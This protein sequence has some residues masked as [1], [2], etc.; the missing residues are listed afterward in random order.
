MEGIV[1]ISTRRVLWMGRCWAEAGIVSL[2]FCL[3]FV[4]RFEG[5]IPTPFANALIWYLPYVLAIKMLVLAG[6]GRFKTPWRVIYLT[7]AGRI[8]TSLGVVTSI[9]IVFAQIREWLPWDWAH[10]MVLPMGVIVLDLVLS[11][12]GLVGVR[13]I[14]RLLNEKRERRAIVNTRGDRVPTLLFGA[15]RAGAM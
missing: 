1:M 15:G 2:A 7:G 11:L 9:L 5:A 14:V 13:A 3:A 12:V 4:L 10:E 8:F 6:A